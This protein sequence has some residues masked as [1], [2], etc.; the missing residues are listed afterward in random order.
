MILKSITIIWSL[1]ILWLSLY[2]FEVDAHGIKL[3][4]NADKII[5]LC[6]HGV[7]S[8]LLAWNIQPEKWTSKKALVLIFA[9]ILY[10]IVIEV[11]QELMNLGRSFDYFDIMANSLGVLLGLTGYFILKKSLHSSAKRN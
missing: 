3:F 1:V 10:G 11:T 9:T 5:H 6:M 8:F 4:S 2:P 7:M